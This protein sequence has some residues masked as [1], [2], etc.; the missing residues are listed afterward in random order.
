MFDIDTYNQMVKEEKQ[1]KEWEKKERN[2]ILKMINPIK[3]Q[4]E[5]SRVFPPV[6]KQDDSY[7]LNG[8]IY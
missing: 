1:V 3:K 6:E 5:W 4:Q 8:V 2:R 7:I